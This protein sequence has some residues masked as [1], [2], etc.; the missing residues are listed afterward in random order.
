MVSVREANTVVLMVLTT[1]CV[2]CWT[3]LGSEEGGQGIYNACARHH[4]SQSES[5]RSSSPRSSD[6]PQQPEPAF[7]IIHPLTLPSD[8]T[9]RDYGDMGGMWVLGAELDGPLDAS[10]P[11]SI[12]IFPCRKAAQQSACHTTWATRRGQRRRAAMVQMA[13]KSAWEDGEN[14]RVMCH[15]TVALLRAAA[16]AAPCVGLAA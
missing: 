16:F 2:R 11:A 7:E 12:Y 15:R 6:R 13:A 4:R 9:P 10:A 1:L 5:S 8:S 3:R 14:Y